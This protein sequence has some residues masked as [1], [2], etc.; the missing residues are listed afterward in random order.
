MKI[1]YHYGDIEFVYLVVVIMVLNYHLSEFL[2]YFK[3]W[4]MIK[5][6]IE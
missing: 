6:Q 2:V 4:V 5:N 3:N 1:N